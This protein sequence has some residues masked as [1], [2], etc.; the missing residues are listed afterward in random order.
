MPEYTSVACGFCHKRFKVRSDQLGRDVLC[1][2]CKTK[3]RIGV[4][5]ELADEAV[6]ALDEE[7]NR[8]RTVPVRGPATLPKGGVRSRKLAI[9][10]VVLLV[11]AF[12]GAAVG[13]VVVYLGRQAE[14]ALPKPLPAP[15]PVK[16]TFAPEQGAGTGFFGVGSKKNGDNPAPADGSSFARA[17]VKRLVRGVRLGTAT[18][19]IGTVHNTSGETIRAM[20]V[21]VV[22]RDDGEQEHGEAIAIIREL[23]PGEVAPLVAECKGEVPLNANQ[24]IVSSGF[25]YD[26][27]AESPTRLSAE[28]EW[29]VP[30]P[31][32]YSSKGKIKT[33]VTNAGDAPVDA[34][35][36]TAIM[37]SES[38]EIIGGARG[39]VRHRLEPGQS[40]ELV[41]PYDHCVN[42]LIR[43]AQVRAQAALP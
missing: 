28:G 23:Q 5:S 42:H 33:V 17:D 4:R 14:P 41:I 32:S 29:W 16:Y 34:V 9:L 39:I 25:H 2:H 37:R 30:D 10:W 38:G 8:R 21:G 12:G 6:R 18:Y 35:E 26:A 19:A 40:Q 3:T 13:L 11:L 22:I 27:V 31:K 1:P 24:W 15:E 43:S 20:E 7:T 36:I